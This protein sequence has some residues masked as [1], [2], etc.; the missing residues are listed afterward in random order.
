[1]APPRLLPETERMEAVY[2]DQIERL[3]NLKYQQAR[4]ERDAQRAL[5]A[6]LATIDAQFETERAGIAQLEP[7]LRQTIEQALREKGELAAA[8]VRRT[9]QDRAKESAKSFEEQRMRWESE[10]FLT[11]DSLVRTRVSS[12]CTLL[13]DNC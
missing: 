12:P 10:L 2:A 5:E 3:R 6:E 8:A 9:Y 11:L 1:M 7:S 13:R 4:E